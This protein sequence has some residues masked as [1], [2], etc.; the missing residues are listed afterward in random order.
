MCYNYREGGGNIFFLQ[1][2]QK[3]H[4]YIGI[5]RTIYKQLIFRD[6]APFRT[7]SNSV[8]ITDRDIEYG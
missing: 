3:I 4:M 6:R 8:P 7:P 2:S 1:I 5:N